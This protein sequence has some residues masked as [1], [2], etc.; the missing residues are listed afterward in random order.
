[1]KPR[2]AMSIV[3]DILCYYGC[4]NKA[5]FVNKSNNYMCSDRANKCPSVREKNSKKIKSLYEKGRDAKNIYKNSSKEAKEKQVW[6]KGKYTAE[7]SYNGFG[8]HKKVLIEER[9][10]KCE[11]CNLT[12]WLRKAI[13]LEL[14]HIDGDRKNNIKEN[15]KLLC[16]NCHSYTPTWR[17]SKKSLLKGLT[18]DVYIANV[19]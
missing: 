11:S 7:F 8:T 12:E 4:G 13:T 16:P 14:E 6:N 15:L 2:Y 18:N 3:T 19:D 10:H 5:N 17:R 1:M 9:G